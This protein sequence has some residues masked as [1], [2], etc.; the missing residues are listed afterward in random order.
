MKIEDITG[1]VAVVTGGSNGIGA[2]ACRDLA[3]AGAQ[4]V[5]CYNS[6][7]ERA[8][9]LLA[10]LPGKGHRIQQ[11][12]QT[13]AASVARLAADVGS[14]YGGKAHILVNSAGFTRPV[15]H[16]NLDALTDEIFDSVLVSNARGPFSV[17]RAMT[18]LLK[19]GGRSVIV[20]V[21]SIAGVLG[22]GSSIAYA[23]SK[24]AMDNY[25]MAL[26][27]VL[28][29]EIRVL[30]VLP[31]G[32]NTGFVSNRTEEQLRQQAQRTPLKLMCEPEDV[33]RTIMACITHLTHTTGA[34]ILIDGGLHLH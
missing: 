13:D 29:P 2:A 11:L 24:A 17:I 31:A 18:P 4:V 5:I 34:R 30:A 1:R 12:D 3:E 28:G 20:N 8:R 16:A 23:A 14:A 15:P 19:A 10:E 27:R 26:A 22:S 32:V 9:A 21:S 7:E 33:S 25:T 6:G